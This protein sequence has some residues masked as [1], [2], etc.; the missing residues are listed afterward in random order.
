MVI[1]AS[2]ECVYRTSKSTLSTVNGGCAGSAS[3]ARRAEGRV[4]VP[5]SPEVSVNSRLAERVGSRIQHRD[6]TIVEVSKAW[7]V[8]MWMSCGCFWVG[9]V[10]DSV[11]VVVVDVELAGERRYVAIEPVEVAAARTN[12]CIG[13][14]C[15]SRTPKGTGR[16]WMM[17][18]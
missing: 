11:V 12:G 3:L 9:V 18:L 8:P 15:M 7:R 6:V 4:K 5:T 2:R 14:K 1:Q 10:K 16:V 13:E 17:W